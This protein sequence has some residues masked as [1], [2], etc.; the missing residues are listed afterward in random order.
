M[1][2]GLALLLGG[3]Y[4]AAYFTAGDKVP[5]GTTVAGIDIGGRTPDAAA[6]ALRGGLA[7]QGATPLVATVDGEEV[8]I[9]PAQ[10]GVSVDVDATVAAAQG[11]R[12]WA[13]GWLWRYFTGGQEVAPVAAVDEVAMTTF[14][15]GLSEQYG[16]PA[17]D[18]SVAFDGTQ[19]RVRQALTGQHID[20]EAARA[21][22]TDG[23]LTLSPVDLPLV[24]DLPEIDGADVRAAVDG[25]ANPAVSG[26]VTLRFGRAR[27]VLA[28]TEFT[29]A[30]RLEP[31]DGELVPSADRKVLAALVDQS[32]SGNGAPVD[33]TVALV[34]G[35]PRVVPA[36][37]GVGYRRADVARVLLE[38]VTREPGKR[39]GK[40]E[41]TVARPDFTTADA[42]KLGIKER[43]STFTT[44]YPYA[45]YRNINIGRAAV[46]VNGTVLKPGDVFSLNGV[47]G[48]RTR[49]NGFTKGF[50]ISNGIFK[51]DLGG[52]VS[53][54]ATTTFNAMFFAGLKDIEHKPH[55]FYIDRYPVGREATVA[56]GAVDLRFQ[57]DTPFG[58]LVQATVTPATSSSSGV[59]TVSMW[60]TKHWDITTKTGDR[61][62]PTKPATRVLTTKDCYPNTGYGG[63][64]ID[65]WRYFRKPGSSALVRSEKFH[66]RYLPS[67]TVICKP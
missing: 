18:G 59:V 65:V 36:K 19:V 38:L 42:R 63:F 16:R 50:I 35:R 23:F 48:E 7:D 62:N 47:V 49:E 12:S 3:G 57:N 20:P 13:P 2:L 9:A 15:D 58:V 43:V 46:L 39:E 53:Q 45:E 67:D 29:A 41:S 28:P 8:S 60:S 14:L 10:A 17:R 64:D 24:T 56:W 51:E 25:F 4:A 27:V 32:I 37:P 26:P 22:L 33:A 6:A 55:S 61:Y 52:G 54:M 21:R 5:L 30:L 44:Y 40:V 31:V 1:L 66:T 34:D 11:E